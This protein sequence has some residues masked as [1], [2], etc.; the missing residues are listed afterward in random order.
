MFE[1][2]QGAV[3]ALD[4]VL[5]K[6][7]E[8]VVFVVGMSTL[9]LVRIQNDAQKDEF[10]RRPC[11]LLISNRNAQ[12]VAHLQGKWDLL[13]AEYRLGWT[14]RQ[15]IVQ[16]MKHILD[17]QVVCADPQEGFSHLVEDKGSRARTEGKHLV[18]ILLPLPAHTK[19]V[20]VLWTN[21]AE[22]ECPADIELGQQGAAAEL[23]NARDGIV[24]LYV[25][26]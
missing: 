2:L 23:H 22:T 4:H 16:E 17:G 9:E 12:I 24:D 3:L 10:G 13:L 6:L 18:V 19:K 25:L 8:V 5:W 7:Q 26:Q 21:R 15:K 20:P 14:Q 1:L 11:S